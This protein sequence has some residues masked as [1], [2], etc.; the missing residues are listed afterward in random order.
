LLFEFPTQRCANA[1]LSQSNAPLRSP[2]DAAVELEGG[3]RWPVAALFDAASPL[4]REAA[5]ALGAELG[6]VGALQGVVRR[7]RGW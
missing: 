2:F 3:R 5:R 7:C 1:G 6:G 4:W